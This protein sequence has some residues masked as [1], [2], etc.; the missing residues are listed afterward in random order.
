M[1]N[2]IS[3]RDFLGGLGALTVG[4]LFSNLVKEGEAKIKK[5]E[6]WP[7]VKIDPKKAGEIA[8]NAWFEVFCAQATATGVMELLAEKVGDPWATFP[9]HALKFGM[10]GM[11]GWGMTCGSIV[12]ASLVMGLV[13]PKEIVN[14]MILDI[15][16]WYAETSLP[17]FVPDKPK[18][19]KDVKDMPKTVANSPLCHIS[20]GK[21]M[22]TA[23]KAFTSPERR[24]RCA[25]VAASVA[26]RT[27]ELLNAWKDGKYK[28][29]HT[30]NGPAAVGIPAQQ[31]CNECHGTNIPVAPKS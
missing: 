10:G 29:T 9:I 23:N 16:E 25:R 5:T 13:L 30:W 11:L 7:Y 17:V 22:K 8:Y 15:V 19:V 12:T 1:L 24:D 3:R 2:L 28:P 18:F 20:V 27:V 14:D 31:N 26:Y 21:W 6:P 4:V